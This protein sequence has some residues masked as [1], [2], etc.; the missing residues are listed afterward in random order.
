MAAMR[1]RQLSSLGPKGFHRVAYTEWG[2]ANARSAVVCV[3]GLTRQGRDFDA[4]AGALADRFRVVCPDVAG[5]GDSE[6]L[7]EAGDYGYPAYLADMAALLARLDVDEVSWVGTSMG[8]LIGIMLAAQPN[9][10]LRRL[11]VNDIGPFIGKEALARI[12]AYV[13]AAGAFASIGAVEAYL[14]DVHAPFG[15][16]TDE[17]WRH[18]ARHG[19]RPDGAGGFRL[20]YDPKIAIPFREAAA[21]DVDLW[22]IWDRVGCPT[23]VLRGARSDLLTRET[24]AEMERRGPRAKIVEIAGCGHAPALMAADQIDVVRRWLA[25]GSV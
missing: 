19:A 17:Q 6:W 8:G 22:A 25:A 11:V 10:P 20:H 1:Q 5:R 23:L 15:P 13:G 21:N 14:R 24:A 16:L 18:L 12:A 2:D 3:H 4:L 7:P 9:S